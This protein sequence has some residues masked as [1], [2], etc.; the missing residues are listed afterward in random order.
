MKR[1]VDGTLKFVVN[2]EDMPVASTGLPKRVLPVLELGGAVTSVTVTSAA[3]H[4]QQH[5]PLVSPGQQQQQLLQPESLD[6][7]LEQSERED[8]SSNGNAATAAASEQVFHE[9]HGRN[10]TLFDGGRRARRAESYN[11]GLALS[12]RPLARGE[13]FA[14][15]LGRANPRWTASL[16]VGLATFRTSLPVTALGLK[17]GSCL[18]S[19]DSLYVDG[20]RTP[21][22]TYRG[23][24]LDSLGEGE[25]VGISLDESNRMRVLVN[26]V[27]QGAVG[28]ELP[29]QSYHVV[30]DLYGQCE[31]VSVCGR[32]P[33][34]PEGGKVDQQSSVL[35]T[36]AGTTKIPVQDSALRHCDYLA[37]CSRFRSSLALPPAHF[38]RAERPRCHCAACHRARADPAYAKKGEPVRD[39]ALPVGWCRFPLARSHHNQQHETWHTAYHG[40]DPRHLRRVLD[41]GELALQGG[42][43]HTLY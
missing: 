11:Q 39:Y 42:L 34:E 5:L 12:G 6:V 29:Q 25:T 32:E 38:S 3:H 37:L 36:A 2:G 18:L 28:P 10:V 13:R 24:N 1:T 31:E 9:N 23:P 19:A 21:R 8:N 27:D 41:S 20:A 40:C 17:K 15:R 35:E 14:V 4:Q 43:A 33:Q 7:V 26:G 22:G 16:M 30:I